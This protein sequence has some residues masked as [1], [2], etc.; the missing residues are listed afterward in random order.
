MKSLKQKTFNGIVWSAVEQFSVQGVQFLFQIFLARIL[1]PSDYGLIAM[2]GIFMAVSQTFIDSGFTNALIR[3]TDRSPID[4]STVFYYNLLISIAIYLVLY[5]FAPSIASFYQS[6]S[7]IKIARIYA[8]ALPVSALASVQRTQYVIKVDFKALASASLVG[9]LIGGM[10]GIILALNGFGVWA[11]VYSYL[12]NSVSTTFVI[13]IR[14]SWRPQKVFSFLA[15]RKMF[16]FGSKLVLSGLLD[17]IYRNLYQVVIGK[18]FSK[19]DLGYYARAEQFAQF[20]SLNITGILQR[21]TYPVLCTMVDNDK[22]LLSAYRR[23]IKMSA[24]I[25]FPLMIGLATISEPLIVVVLGEKWEFSS[26]ILQIICFSYMWYPIHAINLNILMVKGRSDLFFRLEIAKKI[27]GVI[28]LFITMQ[29][30]IIVMAF[31]TIA[32]SFIAL[33][34]N[35]YYTKRFLGYGLKK[36]LIDLIPIFC[37]SC[38]SCLPTLAFLRSREIGI[39][40][41]LLSIVFAILLYTIFSKLF[42]KEEFKFVYELLSSLV[43]R[44]RNNTSIQ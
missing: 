22:E 21:V 26:R 11:L 1:S 2:L 35:T 43:N 23:F 41:L 34:I 15:L 31:G 27:C 32:S 29:F 7:L 28:I 39:V 17:T 4:F 25:V 20:P 10:V 37:I 33:V 14:S 38:I 19:Q 36:Q 44:N 8:L 5:L 24:F 9:A 12:A 3:K 6:P 18:K 13:W 16:S 30:G 40:S 42:L